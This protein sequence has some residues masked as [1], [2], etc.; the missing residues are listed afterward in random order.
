MEPLVHSLKQVG[1][2]TAD[3]RCPHIA[4]A[5]SVG[6]MEASLSTHE[7][8]EACTLTAPSQIWVALGKCM[9]ELIVIEVKESMFSSPG[10]IAALF[11]L[12]NLGQ[13]R[14]R[15]G[16]GMGSKTRL[17][18]RGQRPPLP[19]GKGIGRCGSLVAPAVREGPLWG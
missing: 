11:Q 14:V 7:T 6:H 15:A 4:V 2:L 3:A 5:S 19:R 16:A 9:Q 18:E 10:S 8:A 17:M 1:S 13:I 12:T